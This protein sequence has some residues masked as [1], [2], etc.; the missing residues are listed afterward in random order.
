MIPPTTLDPHASCV[1]KGEACHKS[2][3]QG[4]HRTRRKRNS[5]HYTHARKNTMHHSP[6]F[7]GQTEDDARGGRVTLHMNVCIMLCYACMC[8]CVCVWVGGWVRVCNA[9]RSHD[10]PR[11]DTHACGRLR[12]SFVAKLSKANRKTVYQ[13]NPLALGTPRAHLERAPLLFSVSPILGVPEVSPGA[14]RYLVYRYL[15]RCY[16]RNSEWWLA[17]QYR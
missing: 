5:T 4:A 15:G 7:K 9:R 8:L 11:E 16:R 12:E 2:F 10:V 6:L 17:L 3:V 1:P 13:Q 14:K